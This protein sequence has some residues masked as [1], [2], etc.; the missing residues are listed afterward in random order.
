M[1]FNFIIFDLDG[2]LVDSQQDLTL[3]VNFVRKHYG[4]EELDICEVRSFLGDGITALIDKAL[5]VQTKP[6]LS[7]ALEIFKSFYAQHLTDTTVLYDGVKETL[8]KLKCKKI[9]LLSNKSEKFCKK[10]LKRLGVA[11][12]FDEIF[13]G[14]SCE[15]KKPSPKPI[16]EL[17][18]KTNSVISETILIGDSANDFLSAKKAGIK[19]AAVEYGYC[20]LQTIKEYNP[21]FVVKNFEDILR[22]VE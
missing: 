18:Q 12:F 13:G 3:S 15:E 11:D 2:T 4:F 7:E 10:I 5:P 1:D 20:N 19:S 22:I 8:K 14:D 17:V 16:L 21:D 6:I 9:A